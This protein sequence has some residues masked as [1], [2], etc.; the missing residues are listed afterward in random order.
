MKNRR[1]AVLSVLDASKPQEYVPAA[2]FMHFAPQ[3]HRGRAAAEKH[4]EFFRYTD[5]DLVKIQYELLTPATRDRAARGLGQDAGVRQG[6]LPAQFDVVKG[7]VGVGAD[8]MVIPTLYSPFMW[9][10]RRSAPGRLRR[11]SWR[12]RRRPSGGLGSSRR[13]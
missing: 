4:L 9:R 1:E 8:A 7:L 10:A 3:Y 2:F 6:V 12:S 13:A 5:M 11:I